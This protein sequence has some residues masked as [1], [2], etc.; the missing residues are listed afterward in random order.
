MLEGEAYVEDDRKRNWLIERN[1]D[2]AMFKVGDTIFSWWCESPVC[3]KKNSAA[4]RSQEK[5]RIEKQVEERPETLLPVYGI[6]NRYFNCTLES[7]TGY[8]KLIDSIRLYL[9]QPVYSLLLTGEPGT[10]KTHIAVSILR[11]LIKKGRSNM[12]FKNVPMLMLELRS[13]FTE[14]SPVTEADLIARYAGIGYLVLDDLGTEKPTDY[15]VTS[16]YMIIDQRLSQSRPTIIT[17]NLTLQE[18][19][20]ISPRIA[21]R[22]SEYKVYSFA[23]MKDYRKQ[24]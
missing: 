3:K 16:L 18:I 4:F 20:D 6:G 22:L 10:G 7:F 23:G 1:P 24:R 15:A 12:L 13:T 5:E 2:N 14:N 9:T 11:E 17:T 19:G 21:S 8:Q